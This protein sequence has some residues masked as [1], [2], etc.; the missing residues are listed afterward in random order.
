MTTIVG[1]AGNGD[2]I[3]ARESTGLYYVEGT[4]LQLNR[5]VCH[6]KRGDV[7]YGHQSRTEYCHLD[8]LCSRLRVQRARFATSIR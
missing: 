2:Y 3:G 7:T 5:K 8:V 4:G 6:A 1:G